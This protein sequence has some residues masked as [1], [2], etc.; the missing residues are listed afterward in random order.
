MSSGFPPRTSWRGAGALAL[1]MLFG[2]ANVPTEPVRGASQRGQQQEPLH[3]V[4]EEQP[5]VELNLAPPP[6]PA[7]SNLLEFKL[8][9]MT[10][11]RFFVDGSSLTVAKDKVI[12]FVLVIRTLE[13]GLSVRFSGLRCDD[14]EWKDYAYARDDRTWAPDKN[15]S[16][17]PIQSLKFNAYQKTLYQDYFCIGG[18]MSTH[19]AGDSE[20]LVRLLRH[21]PQQDT[22]VPQRTQ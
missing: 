22:R 1:L 20:K 21:P 4:Q 3:G 9:G 2:C 14:R 16:W 18:V 11:N 15:A 7:D 10:T 5:F 12:R 19:P 8:R 13:G 17:R 6:Y